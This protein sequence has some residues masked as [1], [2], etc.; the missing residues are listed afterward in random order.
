VKPEPLKFCGTTE[1]YERIVAMVVGSENP[2][3]VTIAHLRSRF[4]LPFLFAHLQRHRGVGYAQ[5]AD[6]NDF[7]SRPLSK[8]A[9]GTLDYYYKG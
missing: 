5:V 9:I 7:L 1:G 6:G 8:I 2:I 4:P 3:P